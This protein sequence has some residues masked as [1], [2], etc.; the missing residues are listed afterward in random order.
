MIV[1]WL[2]FIRELFFIAVAVFFLFS[3]CGQG[4]PRL[5]RKRKNRAASQRDPFTTPS[6]LLRAEKHVCVD[7]VIYDLTFSDL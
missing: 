5:R 6:G 2:F 1:V 7:R 3:A 4:V